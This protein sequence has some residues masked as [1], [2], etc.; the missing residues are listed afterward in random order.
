MESYFDSIIISSDLGV[1]KPDEQ[2]Y[3][4]PLQ[5]F[6]ITPEESAFVGDD[7]DRELDGAKAVGLTTVRVRRHEFQAN[8]S[9]GSN[10]KSIDITVRSLSD[11]PHILEFEDSTIRPPDIP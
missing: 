2:I 1:R 5:Q 9:E 11:I 3:L 10:P 7:N 8:Q 6:S 4:E